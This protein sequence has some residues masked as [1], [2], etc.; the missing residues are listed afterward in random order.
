M[1]LTVIN[2]A[3]KFSGKGGRRSERERC[4]ISAWRVWDSLRECSIQILRCE[5]SEGR[6]LASVWE[7]ILDREDRYLSV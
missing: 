4:R 3:G 1:F 6:R 7:S 5:G 2:A